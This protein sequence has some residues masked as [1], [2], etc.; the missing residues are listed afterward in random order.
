MNKLI[1]FVTCVRN[2]RAQWNIKPQEKIKCFLISKNKENLTLL[3]SNKDSLQRLAGI[4]EFLINA[5]LKHGKNTAADLVEDIKVAIPLSEIIDV[6][7]EKKR[8]LNQIE[9][10]KKTALSLSQRLKNK[11][12]IRKA[13]EEVIAKEKERLAT[14]KNKIKELEH[15]LSNFQ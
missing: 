3:D 11:D 7:K 15:A 4:D 6:E 9:E 1:G 5:E 13:P 14:L 8:I 2:I 10:Q 12:F